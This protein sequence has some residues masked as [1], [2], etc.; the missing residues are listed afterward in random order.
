MT[1]PVRVMI[2]HEHRLVGESLADALL[3]EGL[4]VVAVTSDGRDAVL[5]AE[6]ATPDVVVL[7]PDLPRLHG[8]DVCRHMKAT[9]TAGA[10]MVLDDEPSVDHVFEFV[11]SGADG[12]VSQSDDLQVI[13]DG[14]RKAASGEMVLPP[15]L[16][17]GLMERLVA[18]QREVTDAQA[19]V[20][21]LTPREREV[22]ELLVTGASREA[23]AENLGISVNTV[24]THIQN[25]LGR[26]GVHSQLAAVTLAI[27]SGWLDEERALVDA[28]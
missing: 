2:A 8:H 10:V 9:D 13:V 27:T 19:R 23:L 25:I 1:P 11:M 14:L 12:Y 7:R 16:L 5:Q 3:A 6:R 20:Q 15:S 22:L 18:H 21:E 24:R 28:T 26:L 17:R 4:Q